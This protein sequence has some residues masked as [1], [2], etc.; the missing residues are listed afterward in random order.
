MILG[1]RFGMKDKLTSFKNKTID[2]ENKLL[3][4]QLSSREK[5][6]LKDSVVTKNFLDIT[7]AIN[8]D[9]AS[10]IRTNETGNEILKLVDGNFS[11]EDIIKQI[12]KAYAVPETLIEEDIIS[13]ITNCHKKGIIVGDKGN[14]PLNEPEKI[15]IHG[16]SGSTNPIFSS[17]NTVYIDITEK[18]NL[19]CP[20]CYL[21]CSGNRMNELKAED[22]IKTIKEIDQLRAE[23]LFITGGEPLLREDLFDIL[24]GANTKNIKTIGLLTNGTTINS[25]NIDDI[26]DSFNVVQI[27]LDGV[28]KKTHEISRGKETFDQVL[29]SIEILKTA[30]DDSKLDQVLI[31]M[32]VFGEN[33]AEV[34]EMV[35]FAYSK[36]CNLSFF[37]VLPAG[38]ANRSS[39]LHWL[40]SDEYSQVIIDAYKAFSEIV[41]ENLKKGKNTSFYIK[42]SNINYG[43]IYTN[44]PVHNC[45]LG[46]K[47]L[48]IGSDGTVYPCRGLHIPDLSVGNVKDSE[49]DSLYKKSIER[50]SSVSVNKNLA[51]KSCSLKYFCGGGCRLYGYL[52]GELNGN[53]PNCKLYEASIYSA[54]LCKDKNIDELIDTTETMYCNCRIVK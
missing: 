47:E 25:E 52:S 36:N 38:R 14:S 31:S 7:L 34:S 17:L 50:F 13:F 35:R 39:C 11:T 24:N 37:N 6:K 2:L 51:C 5:I 12:S 43:S 41:H 10:W 16:Q 22:W 49:L 45:G 27:A 54:M 48:S 29:K 53:D 15:T 42:P 32:T 28:N 18:C 9:T 20:Y 23:N 26:C 40:T 3:E 4:K 21:D 46:I 44:K 33:K 1:E 8:V 19:K 30:F